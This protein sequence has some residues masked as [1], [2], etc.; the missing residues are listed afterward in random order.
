[1]A[2]QAWLLLMPLA[3]DGGVRSAKAVRAP[4]SFEGNDGNICCFGLRQD[5]LRL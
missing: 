1:M 3:L 4:E 5:G 2:R